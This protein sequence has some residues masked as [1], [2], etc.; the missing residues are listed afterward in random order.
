MV[1]IVIII[2]IILA[3]SIYINF[4]G[5]TTEYADIRAAISTGF[6]TRAFAAETI[7]NY[8]PSLYDI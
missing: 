5:V 3:A 1:I 7:A 6:P 2:M 4:T 8:D